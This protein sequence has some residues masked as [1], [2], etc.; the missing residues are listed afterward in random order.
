MLEIR[1]PNS[2]PWQEAMPQRQGETELAIHLKVVF[3]APERMVTYTRYDPGLVVAPHSHD[4][5]E[6]IYVLEGS[7]QID[8]VACE[9]GTLIVLDG[10]STIG[11]I[12]AGDEGTVLLEMFEGRESW[13]PRP[14][15]PNDA[16]EKLVR[17]RRITEMP[18]AGRAGKR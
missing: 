13:L 3:S 10:D 8:G 18:G 2:V 15:P 7:M 11:P 17:D 12:V 9:Q 16:Y 14:V 1:H 6:V 5:I 4:G